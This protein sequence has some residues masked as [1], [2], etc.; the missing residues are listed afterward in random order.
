MLSPIEPDFHAY[1][2][3]L[4]HL[5]CSRAS[6]RN[7]ASDAAREAMQC[8]SSPPS[9]YATLVSRSSSS[10]SRA[11]GTDA[12]GNSSDIGTMLSFRCTNAGTADEANAEPDVHSKTLGDG[13]W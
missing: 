8:N 3:V 7:P 4:A 11:S 2:S 1:I 12:P 9:S 10:T 5:G 6:L 13:G